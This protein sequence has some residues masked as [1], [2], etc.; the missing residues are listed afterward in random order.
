M[1]LLTM[2]IDFQRLTF[3][4]HLTLTVDTTYYDVVLIAC[5]ETCQFILCDTASA[6]VQKSPIWGLGCIAGNVDEVEIGTVSTT[7][8]PAHSDIHSS[9]DISSEVNTGEGGDGPKS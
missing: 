8:Y 3:T 1:L 4:S 5:H 9:T 2:G 6:D 7:Q